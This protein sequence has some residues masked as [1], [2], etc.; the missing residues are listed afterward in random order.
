MPNTKRGRNRFLR[1]TTVN[2][3]TKVMAIMDYMVEIGL[4]AS[5]SEIMRLYLAKGLAT[6]RKLMALLEKIYPNGAI[7]EHLEFPDVDE[8]EVLAMPKRVKHGGINYNIL[9]PSHEVKKN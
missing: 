8:A 2:I 1:P 3:S 6:D 9:G 7:Y 4:Y 5:R